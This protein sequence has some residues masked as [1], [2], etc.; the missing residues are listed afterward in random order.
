[1]G[2]IAAVFVHG[3]MGSVKQFF[4]LIDLLQDSARIDRYSIA[5]P[6]HDGTIADFKNSDRFA[7]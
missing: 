7:W 6:G 1:M 3:H 5:L 4:P 2:R